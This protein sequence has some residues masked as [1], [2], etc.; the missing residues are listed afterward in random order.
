VRGCGRRPLQTMTS[1]TR[2]VKLLHCAG[3]HVMHLPRRNDERAWKGLQAAGMAQDLS[4]EK[5]AKQYEQLFGWAL[6][7]PAVKPW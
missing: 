3:H 1:C 6:M 2:A 5:A 7:D 4:W